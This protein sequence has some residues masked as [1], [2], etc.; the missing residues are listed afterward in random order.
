[1]RLRSSARGIAL[2]LGSAQFRLGTRDRVIVETPAVV[3]VDGDGRSVAMGHEATALQ[4]SPRYRV[5]RPVQRA[6][7]SD[8]DALLGALLLLFDM[9]PNPGRERPPTMLATSLCAPTTARTAFAECI[10]E[11]WAGGAVEVVDS[12][13]AAALG[14]GIDKADP[15]PVLVVDIGRG[16]TE[17]AV[18]SASRIV[19]AASESVGGDDLDRALHGYL[20]ERH[21][22]DV[23]LA[24][25]EAA[26][27][28][29]SSDPAV[30]AEVVGLD[31]V[32]G[33]RRTRSVSA[34]EVTAATGGVV[35]DIATVAAR[36]IEATPRSLRTQLRPRSFVLTGGASGLVG[37]AER[38]TDTVG[39]GCRGR[40]PSGPRAVINGARAL[41]AA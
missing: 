38:L 24:G 39:V 41:L 4:A 33:L 37:L 30:C 31:A 10:R 1:M 23:P 40:L 27:I 7:L 29:V 17:A 25:I 5:V 11:A 35:D 20:R 9:V 12:P 15:E 26:K 3:A 8:G 18:L 19:A 14:A 36:A 22:L 34:T 2:D 16:A 6:T 28:A 21:G 32:T 13:V